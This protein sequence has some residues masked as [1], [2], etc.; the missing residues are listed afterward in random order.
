MEQTEILRYA[1]QLLKEAKPDEADK[2]LA[3]Y[4]ESGMKRGIAAWA[5]GVIALEQ[6]NHEDALKMFENALKSGYKSYVLYMCLGYAAEHAGQYEKARAA[7]IQAS[8]VPI[9][10]EDAYESLIQMSLENGR[11]DE[12][13]L[14]ISLM[15]RDCPNS[16]VGFWY[17]TERLLADRKAVMAV[18]LLAQ[19]EEK[20]ANL[21]QYWY[22]LSKAL[23]AAGKPAAALEILKKETEKTSSYNIS[24]ALLIN[25]AIASAY[26]ALG[27]YEKAAVLWEDLWERIAD[28]DALV[29]LILFDWKESRYQEALQ[30]IELLLEN[31]V[32]DGNRYWALHSRL[33]IMKELGEE[34]VIAEGEKALKEL[35]EN[36]SPVLRFIYTVSILMTMGR[37][38]EAKELAE[39]LK[40]A[41]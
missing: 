38:D 41:L 5:R 17:K 35:E 3:Q 7:Y 18:Q 32:A 22:Y 37:E 29:G 34:N 23:I 14:F 9:G 30:R 36:A 20:F 39:R 11:M 13:D 19:Q 4:D 8:R 10:R 15:L 26:K 33:T 1:A 40:Q 12:V 21:P 28:R 2:I 6:S 27:H 16:F 24:G 25:K 31:P